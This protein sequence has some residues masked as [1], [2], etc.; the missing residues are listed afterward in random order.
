M[1]RKIKY[2][3][4][5]GVVVI[6]TRYSLDA[7]H[8]ESRWGEIFRILPG[9]PWERTSLVYDGYRD[10]CGDKAAGVWHWSPTLFLC[11]QKFLFPGLSVDK[12][13]ETI[14]SPER[15]SLNSTRKIVYEK[16][17]N[18]YEIFW[19][20]VAKTWTLKG[21]SVMISVWECSTIKYTLHLKRNVK[22]NWLK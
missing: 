22:V 8:I 20:E 5:D 21:H 6:G 14:A 18:F 9:R 19:F 16:F 13:A 7:P 2:F 4:R 1:W 10:F 11:I 3:F 12:I 17:I 15:I